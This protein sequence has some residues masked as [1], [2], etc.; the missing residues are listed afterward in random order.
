VTFTRE[1]VELFNPGQES[2]DTTGWSLDDANDG[3]AQTLGAH[4]VAPGAYLLVE[5][6]RAILNN[7]GDT[8]RLLG[9]TGEVIDSVRFGATP[10]DRSHGRDPLTGAWR[11][12]PHPSPGAANPPAGSDPTAGE[13]ITAPRT[14]PSS[15]ASGLTNPTRPAPTAGATQRGSA[16]PEAAPAPGAAGAPGPR[17][18]PTYE[19]VA[20]TRY[21]LPTAPATPTRATPAGIPPEAPPAEAAPAPPRVQI[22]L[23]IGGLTL[24]IVA[25][26]LLVAERKPSQGQTDKNGVL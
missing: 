9:P 6:E 11:L 13:P 10:T 18:A 20:G 17:A 23:A 4:R 14:D 7:S 24:I 2:V 12:E 1:W 5:L 26:A 15:T 22:G 16:S 25:C 3:G 19:G 8:V 21:R